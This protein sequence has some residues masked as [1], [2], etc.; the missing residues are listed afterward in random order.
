MNFLSV[1]ANDY[2]RVWPAAGTLV[3]WPEQPVTVTR[4]RASI[5]GSYRHGASIDTNLV[6]I[7]EMGREFS[8]PVQFWANRMAKTDRKNKETNEERP[9]VPFIVKKLC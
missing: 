2:K 9:Q 6:L 8:T 5:P 1:A 3:D 7:D 4:S